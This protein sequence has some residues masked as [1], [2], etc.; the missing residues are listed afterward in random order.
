MGAKI[1]GARRWGPGDGGQAAAEIGGG[2]AVDVLVIIG[3]LYGDPC[4]W[5]QGPGRP[6]GAFFMESSWV[7]IKASLGF[8]IFRRG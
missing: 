5:P 4:G 2:Q 3:A 7:T 1:W 8:I 6:H